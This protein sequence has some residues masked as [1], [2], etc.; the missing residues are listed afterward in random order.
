[1]MIRGPLLPLFFMVSL[2][3]PVV[4][5][6]VPEGIHSDAQ[7]PS[8]ICGITAK[9]AEDFEA[10]VRANPKYRQR[11]ADERFL[12]FSSSDSK[13]QWVFATRKNWHYPLA[14]C[15]QLTKGPDGSL[16]LDRDMRCD[17]SRSDCDRAFLEFQALDEQLEKA[18]SG[19]ERG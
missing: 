10:K 1:M 15:R 9:D 18:L 3:Q 17:G 5:Q 11:E 19:K 13:T 7:G 6:L 16:Y 12:L 2:S 8:T 4:A 14:T